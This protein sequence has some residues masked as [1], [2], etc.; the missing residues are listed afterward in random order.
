[1]VFED[2][3]QPAPSTNEQREHKNMLS[4]AAATAAAAA[5]ALEMPLPDFALLKNSRVILWID[6][7]RDGGCDEITQRVRVRA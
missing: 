6:D 1:M 7:N 2:L 5:K 3:E 4:V